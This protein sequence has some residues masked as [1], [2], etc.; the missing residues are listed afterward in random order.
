M[1]LLKKHTLFIWMFEHQQAFSKLQQALCSAPVLGILDL[2]KPFA[3][4]TYAS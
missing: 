4:E 2:S 3:I 1:N